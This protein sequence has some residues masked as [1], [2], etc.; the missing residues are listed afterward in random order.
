MKIIKYV[1]LLGIVFLGAGIAALPVYSGTAQAPGKKA[2]LASGIAS[3]QTKTQPKTNACGDCHSARANDIAAEGKRHRNVPC[4][5]CHFGHPQDPQ[6]PF[7]PCSKCHLQT[8]R[9]HFKLS[10]QCLGCHRNPHTPLKIT[11]RGQDDCLLCHARQVGLITQNR[12]RHT[13]VGC[14]GCHEVHR[15]VPLCTQCHKPHSDAMTAAECKKCH[16]PH[17][18]QVVTYGSDTRSD[19]CGACHGK[20]LALL[21]ASTAAH[22]G[23]ECASCHQEKHKMVPKCRD[24]HGSLHPAGITAKFPQCGQCHNIAHDLNHWLPADGTNVM[25]AGPA[26]QTKAEE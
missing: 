22:N 2:P 5:G 11:F 3:K 24:C 19:E 1:G 23:L 10:G 15:K 20:A 4:V 9:K 17:L 25:P 7:S 18:P 16:K 21:N 14:L 12:S 6:Q 13:A 8:K 26:D